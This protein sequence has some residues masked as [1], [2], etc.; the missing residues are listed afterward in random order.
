MKLGIGIDTGGTYTDAVIYDFEGKTILGSAKSLTTKNDLTVGILGAIDGLPEDLVQQTEIISLSTTL[1]TNACVEDK[2]GRAKLIFFGGDKNVIDQYGCQYGLPSSDE[3]YIQESYTRFSGETDRDPDWELFENQIE[4][5][6]ENLDGVGIIEMNAMRNGASVEKKAKEIF[7]RKHNIPVV[8]GHELFSE[9]NCLRRGASTLL[10]AGLFPVISEFME[11]VKKALA[12]RNIHPSSVV[13]VRSDGSLMSEKFA[14]LRPVETLL[15]GPAASVIGCTQ[16]TDC[17][18]SIVVDMGG[19]TTDI[20]FINNG[21]PVTVT[22]GVSIGRW[23]TFVNGLYVKTFGLGGDSAVHYEGK[24]LYLEEYRVVPLCIA[25]EKY[26]SVIDRLRNLEKKKHTRFLYEFYMLIKDIEDS[27]RYTDEEKAFCR[28]LKD[29]PLLISEAAAAVGKDIYTLHAERLIK[30]GAV[31]ICGLTPTDIMHIKGDFTKY[32]TEASILGAEFVAHNLEVSVEELCDLVYDEV[33]KKLYTNIVKAMLENKYAEYMKN[34]VNESVERFITDTYEEVRDGKPDGLFSVMF[35]TEYTLVGVGAPIFVFL[36]DVARM[37]GTH[38]VIPKNH[39]VAN[40]LG[41]I[42]GSVS[43]EYS[44]EIKP[45]NNAEGT[46]GYIVYGSGGNKTFEKIEDAIDFAVLDATGRVRAEAEKRGAVG[47]ITVTSEIS[48][49]DV[50][51]RGE[52]IYLGTLVTA[53]A[54]GTMGF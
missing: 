45:D 5:G 46:S 41:A 15:C 24:K 3:M 8:C 22:D 48:S 23:R 37:L 16:L 20:A 28:A 12:V 44:V 10:N 13:I 14:S 33:K 27:A 19:T 11:S 9:L 47:E 29:G 1:A 38:A 43:A 50:T 21:V 51:A 53:H 40:A 26:P 42:A 52:K 32:R 36:E 35:K 34:G 4:N 6:F 30:D 49:N 7:Q 54:A 39:E 2:G 31:Q 25:A 18:N 17:P